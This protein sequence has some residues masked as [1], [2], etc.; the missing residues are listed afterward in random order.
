MVCKLNEL[1]VRKQYQTDIRHRFAAL[2]TLSDI[3]DINR[4]LGNIN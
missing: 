4:A 1:V 2:G 3:E